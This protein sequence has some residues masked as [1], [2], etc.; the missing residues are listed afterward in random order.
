TVLD[1]TPRKRDKTDPATYAE[2]EREGVHLFVLDKSVSPEERKD[3]QRFIDT[4]PTP[5]RKKI[6]P[7]LN[8]RHP[9]MIKDD[10]DRPAVFKLLQEFKVPDGLADFS[11]LQVPILPS[12]APIA[13][14]SYPRYEMYRTYLETHNRFPD[15]LPALPDIYQKEIDDMPAETRDAYGVYYSF[16][17][18]ESLSGISN[19]VKDAI[20]IAIRDRT[21]IDYDSS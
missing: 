15:R 21:F 13:D 8:Y 9:L 2:I 1:S 12:D 14:L 16:I 6:S 10:K 7:T 4:V 3:F 5:E 11:E 17:H 20:W 19:L 18:P